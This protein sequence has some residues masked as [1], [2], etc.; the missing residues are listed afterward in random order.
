MRFRLTTIICLFLVILC[1]RSFARPN[2]LEKLRTGV[3]DARHSEDRYNLAMMG[4]DAARFLVQVLSDRNEHASRLAYSLLD[5]YYA[6]PS[7]LPDLAMLF[8]QNTDK[9]IRSSAIHLICS[10]DQNYARIL[11]EPYLENPEMEDILVSVLTILKDKRAIPL[12]HKRL[13]LPDKRRKAALALADFK[14]VRSVPI[15]LEI[16]DD[17]KT[18]GWYR[19]NTIEK[20][21]KIGDV[22]TIPLLLNFL[23]ENY[24]ISGIITRALVQLE[25]SAVFPI[26]SKLEELEAAEPSNKK[27]KILEILSNQ[28]N[29]KLIPSY[30]KALLETNDSTIDFA[31]SKALSNMGNKGFDSLLR[32]LQ[33]KQNIMVLSLLSTY[34]HQAALDTFSS[35]ALDKKHPLR[36]YAIQALLRYG[37]L[38]KV[39]VSQYI[40][41][42]LSDTKPKE[43][44]VIIELLFSLFGDSWNAAIYKHLSQLLANVDQEIRFLT[45]DLIRR[46]NI[47]V[48]EPV[49]KQILQTV[50]GNTRDAAQLVYDH[51][52]EKSQLQLEIT[53]SQHQYDSGEPISLSYRITNVSNHPIKMAFYNLP[54]IS[55]NLKIQQPDKSY[56]IYIGP[57]YALR[58]LSIDDYHSIKPE[59]SITGKIPISKYYKLSQ[60]GL[61]TVQLHISPVNGGLILPSKFSSSD[62]EIPQDKKE[63][64]RFIAWSDTLISSEIPFQIKAPPLHRI[65]QMITSVDLELI[66]EE[67]IKEVSKTCRQLATIG[68]HDTIA[69][70]KG[71]AMIEIT[72]SNDFLYNLKLYAGQ[73]L[74]KY[75]DTDLVPTWIEFI[76][77]KRKDPMSDYTEYLHTLGR[78]GDERAIEPLRQ[79]AFRHA[80]YGL[81]E[82]AALA[83]QQLGDNSAVEWFKKVAY[84]KLRHCDKDERN[85]GVMILNRLYPKKERASVKLHNLKKPKFY[86]KHYNL[87]LNWEEIR[88]KASTPEGLKQLYKNQNPDIKKS[89][90]YE[91]AYRGDS[92]G[93]HLVQEDLH[94]NESSIRMHARETLANLQSK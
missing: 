40:A 88:E 65:N 78:S 37:D 73:L 44:L 52:N 5:E 64:S 67:N 39:E 58:S 59:D 27:S 42:L 23:G 66:T 32:I 92:T 63:K 12:L 77:R 62:K 26:L 71:I 55:L 86:A 75:P 94:A 10:I 48:M 8:Q 72:S 74:L 2:I 89:A 7:I 50:K 49:L 54:T 11:I 60:T 15:L 76:K 29:P 16:L 35:L 9:S 85:K 43:K 68:T 1:V 18:H 46:K 69:A 91:L 47:T 84:R 6:V 87:Y 82:K 20:L 25:P 33:Q 51:L 28:T 31:L 83:L 45:I 24:R 80:N 13:D 56:A 93:I 90:A 38:R 79:I 81:P 19:E 57:H 41:T 30:E 36:I 53:M 14:D 70:I 3:W 34:Q 21:A 4:D 22:H 61:Y 17:Q